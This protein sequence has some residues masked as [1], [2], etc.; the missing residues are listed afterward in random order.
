M[1]EYGLVP[2]GVIS[3]THIHVPSSRLEELLSKLKKE[4]IEKENYGL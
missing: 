2:S 1:E 3:D 4:F